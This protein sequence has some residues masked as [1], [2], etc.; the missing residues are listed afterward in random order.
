MHM[1]YIHVHLRGEEGENACIFWLLSTT[2]IF[3]ALVFISRLEDQHW[4]TFPGSSQMHY[5]TIMSDAVQ[6]FH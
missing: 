1:H 6:D 4:G 5:N 3:A 2:L